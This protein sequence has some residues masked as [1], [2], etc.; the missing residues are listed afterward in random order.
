MLTNQ[1]WLWLNSLTRFFAHTLFFNL[2]SYLP[3]SSDSD[4]LHSHTTFH[5]HFV[6]KSYF[7][8][9]NSDP[10]RLYSHTF[11]AHNLFLILLLT[12]QIWLWLA[13]LT[14]FFRTH[15][16]FK[17]YFP[18]INSDFDRLHSHTFCTH[19]VFKSYYSPIN[20]DLDWLHSHTTFL[21]TLCF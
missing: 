9:I 14:H 10:D 16:I 20:S 19:F 7:S 13:S 11:F 17:S 18:P 12:Y 21:H 2:I 5:T 15:F 1:L 6:F 3:I 4:W 8:P